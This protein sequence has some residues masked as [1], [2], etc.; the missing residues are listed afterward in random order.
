MTEELAKYEA[1]PTP[2]AMMMIAIEKGFDLD[3]VEKAMLLQE[4]WEANEAR[5]AYH[6]A[7]SKFKADPPEI[8]KDKKVSFK[9]GGGTTAYNHAS[10]ANVTDKINKAL[11]ACG[12]SASWETV[13]GE[14]GKV[15]V[16]CRITHSQGHSESTSLTAMPDTSGSKNA[17][18]A[19]GSTISY[20]ERYT[21]LALTGLATHDMDDDGQ[22]APEY[23]TE[24]QA[25]TIS[26]MI[27]DKNA[28]SVKFCEFFKVDSIEK[29]PAKRY[30][31]AVKLLKA[32]KKVEK[33][34]VVQKVEDDLKALIDKK[35]KELGVD[36]PGSN[37]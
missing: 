2:A 7:M 17:I 33:A 25:K 30:D 29:I 21:L 4:R 8:E 12:L 10:L 36:E 1:T 19:I 28:D 22:D 20:L 32:K 15:T 14:A 6:L 27:A 11:S 9:A 3:K 24:E 23:I 16:T 13:Q 26:G 34:P 35:N 37:G 18:Q 5:K 31:E